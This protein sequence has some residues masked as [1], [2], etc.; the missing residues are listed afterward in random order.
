MGEEARLP[1]HGKAERE[2]GDSAGAREAN[3]VGS[4]QVRKVRRQ[5]KNSNGRSFC[6]GQACLTKI[7]STTSLRVGF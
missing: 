4:P 5:S 7:Y 2:I 1:A 6:S 3:D